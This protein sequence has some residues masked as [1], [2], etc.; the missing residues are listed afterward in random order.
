MFFSRKIKTVKSVKVGDQTFVKAMIIKNFGQEIT[1]PAIV[2]FQKN[3][4]SRYALVI[5]FPEGGPRADVG[6][7]GDSVG[8]L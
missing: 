1:R 2:M 3:L 8:T 4:L 6:E 5:G 7:Y